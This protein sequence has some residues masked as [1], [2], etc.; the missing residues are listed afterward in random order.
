[1]RGTLT[2]S[3]RYDQ[4]DQTGALYPVVAFT[5][6]VDEEPLSSLVLDWYLLELTQSTPGNTYSLWNFLRRWLI[7]GLAS[8]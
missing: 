2:S 6:S 4:Q 8:S 7:E 1:M 5:F 3:G